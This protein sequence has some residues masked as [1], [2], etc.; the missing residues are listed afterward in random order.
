MIWIFEHT[1]IP[2]L[3]QCVCST[4]WTGEFCQYV[5]DACLVQPN[6]CTNG[7][8]CITTSQP[9]S[10]PQYTCKCPVG[11]TGETS[12]FAFAPFQGLSGVTDSLRRHTPHPRWGKLVMGWGASDW[13][14]GKVKEETV[15][16][17]AVSTGLQSYEEWRKD[18]YVNRIQI[19]IKNIQTRTGKS[20]YFLW[21]FMGLLLAYLSVKAIQSCSEISL[22]LWNIKV[23][24]CH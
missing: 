8:T 1:L 2:V 20:I 23:G 4:G 6:S 13:C 16:V 17:Q 5:G 12:W 22:P 7:A 3:P 11:F 21:S 9:S 24:C 18:G 14:V 19:T 10:P 15:A